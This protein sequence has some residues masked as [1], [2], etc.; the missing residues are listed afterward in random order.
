[1][2]RFSDTVKQDTPRLVVLFKRG[3][4]G[5]KRGVSGEQFQWGMVGTI[6]LLSLIGAIN[7]VQGK[8]TS[9]ERWEPYEWLNKDCPQEALVITWNR[10]R[11]DFVGSSPFDWFLHRDTPIY[12]MIGMME[13]I[14]A[15][16]TDTNRA[17]Q[18]AAQHMILG[19]DG[20]PV[21]GIIQ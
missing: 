16:L 6:P 12:S 19:P 11:D 10:D 13:T 5:D 17:R 14:K 4:S 20:K 3:V 9:C 21:Q 8:L 15:T 1:M 2:H 7:E 18:A